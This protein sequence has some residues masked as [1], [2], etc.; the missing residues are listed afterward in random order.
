MAW[1]MRF[2]LRL[3][4]RAIS[5]VVLLCVCLDGTPDKNDRTGMGASRAPTEATAA[6]HFTANTYRIA[7]MY[8]RPSDLF[9]LGTIRSQD[10]SGRRSDRDQKARLPA[11][12]VHFEVWIALQ[13]VLDGNER[14]LGAERQA[15]LRPAVVAVSPRGGDQRRQR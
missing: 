8:R 7:K 6:S 12:G 2:F 14:A 13:Q 4:G 15:I 1:R 9:D 5:M 11:A 10:R 3:D